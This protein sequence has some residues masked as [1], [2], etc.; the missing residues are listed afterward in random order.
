MTRLIGDLLD[1]TAIE[2]GRLSIEPAPQPPAAL[3]VEAAQAFRAAAQERGIAVLVAAG[4]DLLPVRAD[5]DRVLQVL[6]NLVSN[7]IKVTPRGGRIE[8]RA[9]LAGGEVVFEVSDTGPGIPAAERGRI[10][11][12]YERGA[13]PG[14][15]GTG[16]GLAIARGI[17]EAHGGR[18]WVSEGEGPGATFAFTLPVVDEGEREEAAV[19]N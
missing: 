1:A 8:L 18:I 11:E 6:S 9:A 12:P 19:V 14:Y 3:L 7:G 4:S 10:F 16:L 17:V 15:A 5:R 13:S 2:S